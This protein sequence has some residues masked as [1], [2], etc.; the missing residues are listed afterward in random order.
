MN[1][2]HHMPEF[3]AMTTPKTLITGASAGIGATYAERFAQRGHDLVL[4]ARD[5][6]KL[7]ALAARL[8]SET[9]VSIEILRADLTDAADLA[10]VEAKLREDAAITTLVNNAGASVAGAFTA[11]RPEDISRLIALNVTA[12]TRLGHAV[13]PRFAASGGGTII[14]IASVVGLVP[15]F[16]M[17]V[18]GATK[19]FVLFLSQGLQVELAPLGVRVQ[20]VLPGATGTELWD[21]AGS[22]P[23]KL[24]PMMTVAALVDAALAGLD[25]GE[26]I[27]IP[28][29]SEAG[30]WDSYQSAR[31]AMLPG[32]GNT[33]P[34]A[35]YRA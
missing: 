16:S 5:Q 26:A 12:V 3:N 13:A 10:Q 19:A 11:Q 14:N 27:T 21:K 24:P 28:P 31:H 35:R 6:A 29:L 8:R 9:D 33:V 7:D 2:T 23:A 22:D 15:E 18:Y 4:V 32:F 17:S 25:A 30:L 34:A 20:A 1:I